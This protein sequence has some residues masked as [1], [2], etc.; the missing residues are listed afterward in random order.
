MKRKKEREKQENKAKV[1]HI[2]LQ[3]KNASSST[4]RITLAQRCIHT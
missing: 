2:Y 4:A 1:T 3:Y